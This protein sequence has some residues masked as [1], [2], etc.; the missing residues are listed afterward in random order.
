V[1]FFSLNISVAYWAEKILF[2]EGEGSINRPFS[3]TLF[4][5]QVLKIKPFHKIHWTKEHSLAIF[6]KYHPIEK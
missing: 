6:S 3:Y 4:L 2:V 5:L 1:A